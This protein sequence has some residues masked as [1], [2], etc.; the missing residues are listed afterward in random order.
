MSVWS[1]LPN[2]VH[3]DRVIA[4]ANAYPELWKQAWYQVGNL[5]GNLA[6]NLAWVQVWKQGRDQARDLAGNQA[7][8]QVCY[9]A[10]GVVLA[11]ITYDDCAKYLDIP[12]DQ[13]EMLYHLTEH[14]ACILLQPAVLVFA[15]EGELA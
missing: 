8:D 15:M 5:E 9:Q 3:I 10:K 11:L 7:G 2:A 14:P 4:S 12:L 13:L 6:G 1:H